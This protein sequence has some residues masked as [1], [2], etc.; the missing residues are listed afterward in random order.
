MCPKVNLGLAVKALKIGLPI[1]GS[2]ILGVFVNFSDKYFIE[3]YCSLADLS[4]YYLS[5]TLAN[6]ITIVFS[7]FQNVWLPLFLKEKDVSLN[8]AKTKKTFLVLGGV[9]VAIALFIWFGLFMAI[10]F[11]IIDEKY[12]GVL[13]I[14]PYAMITCIISG[15]TGL[16]SNYVIYWNMTF[17]TIL[18]GVFVACI[19]LPLNYFGS[20]LYGIL[21]VS[22]VGVLV[23]A[24]Q[25]NLYYIFILIKKKQYV[26]I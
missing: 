13:R 9:F 25:F 10:F 1:M 22:V 21:G 5:F 24:V 2:A 12:S 6:I 8:L 16:L 4:V 7:A 3:K 20:K 23:S 11:E 26:N 17:L 19:S 14:L 15:L 18:F